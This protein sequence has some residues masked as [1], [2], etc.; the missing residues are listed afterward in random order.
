MS[1]LSSTPSPRRHLDVVQVHW[2]ELID[3]RTNSRVPVVDGRTFSVAAVAAVSRFRIVPELTTA[4][5]ILAK[6]DAAATIVAQFVAQSALSGAGSM[7]GTTTGFGGSVPKLQRVLIQGLQAGITLPPPRQESEGDGVPLAVGIRLITPEEWVKAIRM[8]SLVRGHSGVRLSV[9]ESLGQLLKE[10]IIPCPPLRQTISASGDLGPL[11]YIAGA[12]TGDNHCLVWDGEGSSRALTTA[13]LALSRRSLTPLE[14]LPKEG[15][16][17]VNGTAPSCA[18]AAC[19]LHDAHFLLLLSQATTAMSVEVLLG[20]AE[21]FTPFISEVARPHPGQVEVSMNIRNALSGSK[22]VQSYDERNATERLRQDRYSLRTAPQWLGPQ[23][24]ELLSAHHTIT[25]EINS[26]TDNPIIDVSKGERGNISGGN[27]QGTSLTVAMEK[28]R[29]GLQHVGR[30]AYAQLVELGSPSMNR[31]LAPDLA[32]NEPSFDYGQKA[33]D[34]ACAAY[35]AEL[36][37]VANTVSNHVQ[38]AEMHNQSVNS[39]AMISARYTATAVQLV[40]MILSNLL[41]SVCQASDLRAMYAAF[42]VK[43]G[44]NLHDTLSATITPPLPP[45]EM[46]RLCAILADQVKASFGETSWL[47]TKDRFHT[48]CKPLLA[49]VHTFL[50]AQ[51]LSDMYSFNGHAFHTTLAASLAAAWI[52]NRDT[53]F[54]DGS[55]EELL[56]HG[57]Q[58]L[59]RWV[60]RGLGLSMRRGIDID[61]GTIDLDVSKIY[62]GIVNGDVND[63]LVD[64]FGGI[65]MSQ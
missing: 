51:A 60:R 22:L 53:Y 57:T 16:A 15:L 5:D 7:Y 14:L 56:G 44:D 11:A 62:E 8:N 63:V 65:E 31:G 45:P 20:T 42:F 54:R 32:A 30:I 3:Y 2:R 38:P 36:S 35:L 34:M 9:I 41:L 37:F 26:T 4:E 1:R 58:K 12:L 64:V 18:V 48:M 10:N 59:Y 23:V 52:S 21:S 46:D 61:R 28:V 43:L 17:I 6:V 39:L 49:D 47:D 40:Q 50:V 29:I 19:T 55:A 27:F 25:I 33:L 24:E 13:P